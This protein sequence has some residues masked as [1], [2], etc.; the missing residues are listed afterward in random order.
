MNNLI[1]DIKLII[2]NKKLLISV[3]I[4]IIAICVIGGTYSYSNNDEYGI[5]VGIVNN[6]DTEYSKLLINFFKTNESFSELA[7]IVED[8]ENTIVS[9]FETGNIDAYIIIPRDFAESLMDIEST[10]V[11][12][13]INEEKE[14]EALMLKAIMQ[15]YEKYVTSVQ[16][17]S[18]G[19]YKNLKRCG[20]PR[21]E[22]IKINLLS[23]WDM[24]YM[25]LDKERFFDYKIIQN[26]GV[27]I[28]QHYICVIL[29]MIILYFSLYVG[30]D[31]YK[32]KKSGVF[33]IY[34][35]ANGRLWSIILSK[36]C[37]YG[38]ILNIFLLIIS[39]YILK[40]VNK[41]ITLKYAFIVV[42][43]SL[44]V[45][46]I[47]TALALVI[48]NK[49]TYV[50]LMNTIVLFIIILGGGIIPKMFMPSNIK[51]LV[52]NLPLGVFID[53]IGRSL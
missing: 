40:I 16:F 24:V 49:N 8:N 39:K 34:K 11:K 41:K 43:Y 30:L 51:I 46:V 15:S 3:G 9:E 4:L 5:R 26:D 29:F 50:L 12:V 36:I 18:Y 20:L 22:N 45:M 28:Y 10:R 52:D 17:N 44:L 27:N 23:S 13:R 1:K 2:Y 31:I 19:L 35:V 6:D 37:V 7:H 21:K 47:M 48:S 25:V 42:V 53:K 33:N 32:E 38:S 14:V